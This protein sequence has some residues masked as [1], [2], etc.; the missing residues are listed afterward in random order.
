MLAIPALVMAMS[1][2][3]GAAQDVLAVD[4]LPIQISVPEGWKGETLGDHGPSL[5]LERRRPPTFVTALWLPGFQPTLTEDNA[6]ILLDMIPPVPGVETGPEEITLIRQP[7]L[8]S[9]LLVSTTGETPSLEIELLS[10]L[11]PVG[12]GVGLV[13]VAA[14]SQ[15]IAEDALDEIA[16]AMI[17]TAPALSEEALSFGAHTSVHGYT[18]ELPPSFRALTAVEAERIGSGMAEHRSKED[19]ILSVA[20]FLDPSDLSAERSFMCRTTRG[21]LEVVDPAKDPSYMHRVQE[22]LRGALRDGAYT[23]DDRLRTPWSPYPR[24]QEPIHISPADPGSLA[25]IDLGDREG[26]LWRVPAIRGATDGAILALYTSWDNIGLDCVFFTGTP[27]DPLLEPIAQAFRSVR[28]TD[29]AG[30][31]MRLSVRAQYIQLWPWTHPLLQIWWFGLGLLGMAAV[32]ALWALR[33]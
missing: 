31:P 22:H 20:S 1:A 11:F 12:S 28:V 21:A 2:P 7:D 14:Q 32:S 15:E 33:A 9:T 19:H 17:V 13:R 18:L 23:V 5:Y 4:A 6:G 3:V 16:A 27:D 25:S 30:H 26:Y 8:G 10:A 29:G 24:A